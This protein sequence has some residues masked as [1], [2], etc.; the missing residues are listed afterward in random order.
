M[1]SLS[2][3]QNSLESGTG[4]RVATPSHSAPIRLANGSPS[5]FL[6]TPTLGGKWIW[7]SVEKG[8]STL[9]AAPSGYKIYV[10]S[11]IFGVISKKLMCTVNF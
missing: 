1:A 11:A 9:L 10:F 5:N 6:R 4:S 3:L 8:D 2:Q 7:K